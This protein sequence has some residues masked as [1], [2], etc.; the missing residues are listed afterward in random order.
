M[1]TSVLKILAGIDDDVSEIAIV[2]AESSPGSCG[3]LIELSGYWLPG[4][5]HNLA[6]YAVNSVG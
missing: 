4:V 1:P 3:I 6:L 2:A 5:L